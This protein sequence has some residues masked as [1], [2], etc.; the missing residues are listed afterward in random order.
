MAM[1][2]L[3]RP[4]RYVDRQWIELARP[5]LRYSAS[6]DA[7]ILRLI[8]QRWGPVLR[9]E[10]RDATATRFDGVERRRSLAGAA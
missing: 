1:R 8:G 10:R 4:R 2:T 6:R 3:K 7:Y 5:L 9:V